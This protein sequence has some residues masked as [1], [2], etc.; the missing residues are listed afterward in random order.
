M[1]QDK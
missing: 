1:Y